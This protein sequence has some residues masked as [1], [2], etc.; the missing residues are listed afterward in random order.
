[1]SIILSYWHCLKGTWHSQAGTILVPSSGNIIKL[2]QMLLW[3]HP[4]MTMK[5]FSHGIL[6]FDDTRGLHEA[7]PLTTTVL[8]LEHKVLGTRLHLLLPD[9][10][11]GHLDLHPRHNHRT[12]HNAKQ[13]LE[14]KLLPSAWLHD[15]GE[16]LGNLGIKILG[17]Y[18]LAPYTASPS[19]L[20]VKV[21]DH[22]TNSNTPW[23]RNTQ[24]TPDTGI[25][26]SPSARRDD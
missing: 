25:R 11:S 7:I 21:I 16:A 14:S 22:H 4:S 6:A 24:H 18:K 15:G 5:P 26:R 10:E 17:G 8:A 2:S 1:M 12:E 23:L 9:W 20:R 3:N 19:R 13:I